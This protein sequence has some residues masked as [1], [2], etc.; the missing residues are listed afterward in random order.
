MALVHE[1]SGGLDV[2]AGDGRGELAHPLP[3]HVVVDVAGD[4]AV[5]YAR[6]WSPLITE[7]DGWSWWQPTDWSEPFNRFVPEYQLGSTYPA[8]R[9]AALR[10]QRAAVSEPSEPSRTIPTV[11]REIIGFQADDVG[12]WV[13]QLDCHHRQHVRHDPPFRLAAWVEDPDERAQH[14]G[15]A[16]A[17]PLCDRCELPAD[18]RVVRTTAT[19]D[20]HTMPAA[21]RRGHRV[22][23]GTWGRLRVTE[24]SLRFVALTDPPTDV[25]VDAEHPQGIPPDVEHHVEPRGPTRFA[26]DFLVPGI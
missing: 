24:G 8:Y 2:P 4:V 6:R 23:R 12:D 1:P 5:R 25:V 19:W 26:I 20:D 10:N 11:R 13:A 16:L 21:L 9:L 3:E 22:A 14:L 7:R 18:L 17:C 15:T